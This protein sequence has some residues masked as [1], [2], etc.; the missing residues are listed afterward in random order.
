VQAAPR[1]LRKR[2]QDCYNTVEKEETRKQK[3]G[4]SSLTSSLQSAALR[5]L[6]CVLLELL[7]A[8]EVQLLSSSCE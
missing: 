7:F 6:L 1:E 5:E 4:A 8:A 3:N 2:E